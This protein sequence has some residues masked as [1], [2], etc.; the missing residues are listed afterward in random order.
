MSQNID[1]ERKKSKI[2]LMKKCS[3]AKEKKEEME[4][5]KDGRETKI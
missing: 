5:G 2:G 4:H 1:L 3:K